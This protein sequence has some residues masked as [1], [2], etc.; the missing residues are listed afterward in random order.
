MQS[1]CAAAARRKALITAYRKPMPSLSP[2]QRG[3]SFV[4]YRIA[5]AGRMLRH[6]ALGFHPKPRKGLRP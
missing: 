2:M 4:A 5:T 3:Y 1:W 6:Q